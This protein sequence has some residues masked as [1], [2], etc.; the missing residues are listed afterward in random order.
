MPR[1]VPAD[2]A[3]DSPR[4]AGGVILTA[5]PRVHPGGMSLGMSPEVVPFDIYGSVHKVN[6]PSP[7]TLLPSLGSPY[8]LL[9][10][11]LSISRY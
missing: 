10:D 3:R 8:G 6:S 2:I 11:N 1:M 9:R 7:F 4:V 5:V